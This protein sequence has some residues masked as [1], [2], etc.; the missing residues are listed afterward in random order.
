MNLEDA[1][2]STAPPELFFPE[3]KRKREQELAAKMVCATCDIKQE[4]LKAALD[5]NEIGIWGG[6]TEE[7]RK[8]LRKGR[9]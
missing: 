3:G 2:C 5:G 4:C 9:R 6:T 7:E 1:A 8:L